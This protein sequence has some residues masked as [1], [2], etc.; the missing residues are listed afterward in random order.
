MKY[1]FFPIF[2]LILLFSAK[3]Q[4]QLLFST[5]FDT[6]NNNISNGLY[7]KSSTSGSYQI[8]KYRVKG[9]IQFDL[10]NAG[11]GFHSGTNLLVAKEFYIREF[12]FEA[13]GLILYNTFSPLIHE[14]NRGVLIKIP[15]KHFNYKFG[16]EF[17]TYHI[18][19]RAKNDYNITSNKKL[20]ENR[21]LI[22]LIKYSL[23]PPEHKW[24]VSASVTNIDHFLINQET[25]P[26][27]N[28]EGRYEVSS[29]L[30]LFGESWYKS[31]G[32]L[33]ISSNYFGF[34][35]RTGIIWEPNL[36]K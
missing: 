33:N 14:L 7:I 36:K 28:V 12:H 9:G 20:N 5:Y 23:N 29:L 22:Y 34:F 6:G 2:F 15:R 19:N 35:F 27:I 3:V 30:T 21:N 4:A 16:T 32:S 26:M 25:N 17:R 10:K 1:K 13:Q 31:A 11:S 18:T 8:N 24:N